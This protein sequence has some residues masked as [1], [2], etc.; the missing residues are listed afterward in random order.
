MASSVRDRNREPGALLA[1]FALKLTWPFVPHLAALGTSLTLTTQLSLD[2]LERPN[3]HRHEP[4]AHFGDSLT[5]DFVAGVRIGGAAQASLC[6]VLIT[7]LLRSSDIRARV[8]FLMTGLSS[9]TVVFWV[10]LVTVGFI[11]VVL[12]RK[13]TRPAILGCAM[14]AFIL[15]SLFAAG[16]PNYVPAMSRGQGAIISAATLVTCLGIILWERRQVRR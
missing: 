15:T 12:V 13:P 10:I 1:N 6:I 8:P 3:G 4:T 16:V 5:P 14:V 2:T 9:L 11:A 7:T